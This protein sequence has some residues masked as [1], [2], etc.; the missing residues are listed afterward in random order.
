MPAVYKLIEILNEKGFNADVIFISHNEK[1]NIKKYDKLKFNQ[2][3]NINFYIFPF[4]KAF[5]PGL[6]YLKIRHIINALRLIYRNKYDLIYCD[7]VNV[8]YGGIFFQIRS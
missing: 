5:I 7:R 1:D 6:T 8:E 3:N 4:Y 2:L